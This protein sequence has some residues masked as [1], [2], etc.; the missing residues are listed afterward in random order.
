MSNFLLI[1]TSTACCSVAIAK[2][3]EVLYQKIIETGNQHATM[4]P[5]FSQACLQSTNILLKDI[6]AIGISIGPGSYTGL[7]V[8]LSFAKA[9]CYANKIPLIAVSTLQMITYGMLTITN[10]AKGIYL[11]MIDA[12]RMEVFTAM[13]NE[14]S[15]FIKEPFPKIINDSFIN[16]LPSNEKIF[17]AGNGAFKLKSFNHQHSIQIIDD[18]IC[19]AQYLATPTYEKFSKYD[20]SDIVNTEPFYLKQFGEIVV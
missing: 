8:G 19:K 16:E 7:R 17:A 12:R 14:K 15:D 4:L 5:A 3:N 10:H 13:I 6:K 11:P 9:I 1:D 18:Q 20:F 2:D